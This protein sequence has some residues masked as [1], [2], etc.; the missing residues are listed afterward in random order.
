MKGYCI[1]C[2]QMKEMTDISTQKSRN[3][4]YMHTGDCET[5]SSLITKYVKDH[6]FETVKNGKINKRLPKKMFNG[7]HTPNIIKEEIRKY[8]KDKKDK[9]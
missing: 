1:N 2:G 4:R 8:K 3:S 6:E 7:K 9:N 5:C